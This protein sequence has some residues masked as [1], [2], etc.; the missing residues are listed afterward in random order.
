MNKISIDI[1]YSSSKIM[2]N[3]QFYKVPTAISFANDAGIDFGE[4]SI[5]SFEGEDYYEY[6][7]EI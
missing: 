4:S 2:F 7:D 1:G 5:Y 6:E 3:D